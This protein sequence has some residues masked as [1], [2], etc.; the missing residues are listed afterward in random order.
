MFQVQF[1]YSVGALLN[2]FSFFSSIFGLCK[3]YGKEKLGMPSLILWVLIASSCSQLIA[4][5]IYGG[6]GIGNYTYYEP[7]YSIIIA[8]VALGVNFLC[9]ALLL[10]EI[11]TKRTTQ[12]V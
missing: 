4:L 2:L 9:C 10:V 8:A 1:F 6:K 7:D 12:K 11:I 3:D 5:C